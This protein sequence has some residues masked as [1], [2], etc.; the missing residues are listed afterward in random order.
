[1]DAA[2][3]ARFCRV[4]YDSQFAFVGDAGGR[5]VAIAQYFRLPRPPD[6]AEVAFAVEDA[7]QRQGIGTRLLDRLADV[8]RSRGIRTFEADYL[9]ENKRMGDVFR[10]CG[11]TARE[12]RL[13]GGIEKVVLDITATPAYEEH[14][15]GRSEQAAFASMRRLFEPRVVAV[16][17]ASAE[18]DK[19]GTEILHNLR[20]RLRG[21]IVPVHPKHEEI[22]GSKT[23]SARHRRPGRRR[24]GRHRDPGGRR[25]RRSSTTASPRA[26]RQSCV[27]SAGFGE[28]SQ[29]GRASETAAL[30]EKVRG[31]RHA[32]SSARTAWACSTPIRA[33]V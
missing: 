15:L 16:I 26:S 13:D 11:F 19:I 10:N 27:I 30:L 22:L 33:C 20:S 12:R 18:R 25:S 7:L 29:E 28:G 23:L 17:G 5:I 6:R 8:A 4:D 2:A 32:G 31:G 21:E 9:A 24:S 3:A 1:M 14:A